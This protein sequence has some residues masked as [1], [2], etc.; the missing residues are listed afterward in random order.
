MAASAHESAQSEKLAPSPAY[1]MH[2]LQFLLL[3]APL[4]ANASGGNAR[5]LQEGGGYQTASSVKPAPAPSGR[6]ESE[7]SFLI[8][9]PQRLLAPLATCLLAPLATCFAF[10]TS[11]PGHTPLS[12][13]R[14]VN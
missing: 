4:L 6:T 9:R 7:P 14:P 2:V 10:R 11:P 12:V 5:R 3:L 13:V 1:V 8:V